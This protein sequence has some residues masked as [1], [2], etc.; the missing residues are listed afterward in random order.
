MRAAVAAVWAV[1]V[2]MFLI[3]AGNGLQTDLISLRGSAAFSSGVMGLMMACYYVGYCLASLNG[4]RL[5]GRLGHV[6]AVI[7]AMGVTAMVIVI[8]PFW[9]RIPVWT[10]LRALSGFALSLSYVAVESWINDRVPNAL[11]GRVFSIYMFAQLAGMTLAQALV[12]L[13]N[14]IDLKMFLIAAGLFVV[15]AVPVAV[16][17]GSAPFGVPPEPFPLVRL[18]RLSPL[19]AWATI[20]AGLS[21]SIIFTFGPVFAHRMGF[22]L[23]GI[24]LFMGVALIAGGILQLPIGWLSDVVGRRPVLIGVFVSGAVVCLAALLPQPRFMVLIAAALAGAFVFPVYTVSAATVNDHV[25]PETRVATA[26]GLVLLFGIGS[27]F[28]PLLCGWAMA[29]I[30]VSGYY[31]LMALT[32]G[33]GAVLALSAR[34]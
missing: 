34:R 25:S 6:N 10:G 1:I 16:A 13:G 30:G 33:G 24:G 28:G 2:S 18:F 31:G 21:W 15:A 11:R 22:D 9:V 17:R 26:S 20:L 32:M 3:Q 23:P 4:R 29:E 14:A 27:I 19:G 7:A 12:G 8:H 5:I